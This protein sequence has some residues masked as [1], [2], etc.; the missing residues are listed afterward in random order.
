M[1]IEGHVHVYTCINTHLHMSLI[2][3]AICIVHVHCS[4]AARVLC[5]C[6]SMYIRRHYI[7]MILLFWRKRSATLFKSANPCTYYVITMDTLCTHR[8]D[9][10]DVEGDVIYPDIMFCVDSFEEVGELKLLQRPCPYLQYV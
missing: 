3:Q 9:K 10:K 4:C 8:M 7:D 5:T 1:C 2:L 6:I